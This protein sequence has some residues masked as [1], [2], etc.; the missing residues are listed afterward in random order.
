MKRI[1]LSPLGKTWI[2]DL[3]G[4]IVKHNGYKLDGH[5]TLLEGAE[6][7]LHDI[8][9]ED[10]IVIITSRTEEQREM[11]GKFLAEHRIRYDHIIYNAPF[12]ER[13]LINDRK[14]SGL[15]TAIAIDTERDKFCKI[16]FII[17]EK[18]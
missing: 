13:I 8:P 18:L 2:I 5:D 17:D 16:N 9:K 10:L 3:D 12:G 15:R 1:M 4:T 6:A 11:T 14:P 7:F